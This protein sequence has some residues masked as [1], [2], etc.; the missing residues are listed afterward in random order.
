MH[1]ALL[2]LLLAVGGPG[3]A[4]AQTYYA[5]NADPARKVKIPPYVVKKFS[6]AFPGAPVDSCY[7][8]G[9]ADKGEESYSFF[10]HRVNRVLEANF[11]ERG[12][13]TES[14][15]EVAVETL[16]EALQAALAPQRLGAARLGRVTK[17]VY[18]QEANRV[19]Y[20]VE[21]LSDEAGKST[22]HLQY[23]A[24][25]GQPISAEGRE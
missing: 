5:Q 11:N 16:P 3:S 8:F 13:L 2:I 15:T 7:V 1:K 9:N 10:T 12:E 23:F 6:Q 14:A 22:T 4:L 18:H 21:C 20:R 19:E 24:E 25:D 17:T